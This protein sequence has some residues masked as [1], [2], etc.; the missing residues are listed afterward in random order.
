MGAKAEQEKPLED[1]R[2]NLREHIQA[3]KRDLKD[4]GV[5]G[6]KQE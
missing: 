4:L 1:W 3:L 6:G 2:Q 5:P